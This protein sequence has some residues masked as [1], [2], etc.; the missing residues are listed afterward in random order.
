MR[1]KL[2]NEA[3][4]TTIGSREWPEAL[5]GPGVLVD[6]D[7]W[8]LDDDEVDDGCETSN[9][10]TS[11]TIIEG[12]PPPRI[13]ASNENVVPEPASNI[14]VLSNARPANIPVYDDGNFEEVY[15]KSIATLL[16]IVETQFRQ[17]AWNDTPLEVHQ[18]ATNQEVRLIQRYS[19]CM[20]T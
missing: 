1:L 15:A 18:P 14:R 19:I 10:T 9:P 13:D 20:L 17:L 3:L 8:M 6:D 2:A 16:K 11:N 4:P 7:D 5:D 12:V